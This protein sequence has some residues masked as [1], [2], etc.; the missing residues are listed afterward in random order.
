[1][2]VVR[3]VSEMKVA[4]MRWR[5]CGQRVGLVASMGALHAGHRSLMAHARLDS[6]ITVVSLFVNPAQ[7]GA[8]TEY[9]SYPRS[10]DTDSAVCRK[11]GADILFAPSVE[12][13]Y[14]PGFDTWVDPGELGSRYEGAVRPGHFRAVGTI[15]LKLFEL[16]QPSFAMFG[17]KDAQQL[18]LIRRMVRDLDLP[19]DV[20][21]VPTVRE[22]DG[23]A[24]SSR[25]HLLTPAQR[26]HAPALYS[27]LQEAAAL[28][29]QGERRAQALRDSILSALADAPGLEV[30]YADLVEPDGFRSL[31]EALPGS[32]LIAAARL[33][34]VRLID[35]LPLEAP[36]DGP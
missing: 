27:S 18:A 28:Y 21:A 35:N 8:D 23:L 11:A 14:P 30:E 36:A 1:M 17:Q 5:A 10:L 29:S 6:D 15:V 25:N 34:E 32:L 7:F 3:S 4:A 2:R 20:K 16:T 19:V 31:K 12:E 13:I 9:S 26:Q 24:V 22:P 33:G